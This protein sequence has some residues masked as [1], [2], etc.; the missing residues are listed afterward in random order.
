[1]DIFCEEEE[2]GLQIFK[3]F[4]NTYKQTTNWVEII[5]RYIFDSNT[6]TIDKGEFT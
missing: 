4:Y 3:I 6:N 2:Y 5:D 1:V